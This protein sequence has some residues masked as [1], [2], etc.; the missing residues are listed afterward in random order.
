MRSRTEEGTDY[1]RLIHLFLNQIDDQEAF[2]QIY[3]IVRTIAL[4]ERSKK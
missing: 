4:E 3:A 1:K 2:I